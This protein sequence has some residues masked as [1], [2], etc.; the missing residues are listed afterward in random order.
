M[1]LLQRDRTTLERAQPPLKPDGT[2]TGRA[3][4][5]P[6][7]FKVVSASCSA[8]FPACFPAWPAGFPFFIKAWPPLDTT[9]LKRSSEGVA[10]LMEYFGVT[11]FN[12]LR[13]TR[14]VWTCLFYV[15]DFFTQFAIK[16]WRFNFNPYL[17]PL[18]IL[19]TQISLYETHLFQ[20]L[21][22]FWERL[23]T[24]L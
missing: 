5:H 7:H 16:I 18:L 15:F 24:V 17:D 23:C 10:L 22:V 12:F 1:N 8:C 20:R 19:L 3:S 13:P 9:F 14:Q 4:S 2:H 11:C 6:G 21:S